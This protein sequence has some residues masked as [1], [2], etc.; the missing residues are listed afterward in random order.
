M[1]S[2]NGAALSAIKPRDAERPPAEK[3]RRER[4]SELTDGLLTWLHN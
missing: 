4:V 3:L 1:Y 2:W